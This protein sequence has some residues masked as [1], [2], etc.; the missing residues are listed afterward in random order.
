M[1]NRGPMA[2]GRGPGAGAPGRPGGG[3]MGMGG[4]PAGKARDLGKTLRQLLGRLRPEVPLIIGAALLG[5]GSVAFAVIGPKIIGNATNVIFN[6]IVG[7]MLPA[8]ITKAQ[9]VA[10]LHARGQDQLAQM[11]SGMNVTPGKG[12]D[13]GQLG[14]ILL[15]AVGV[16]VASSVFTWAQGYIMAG[17]A[18]R[19]VYGMRRDVESKLARLPLKYFDSHSHGD[20]LSLS[21]IHI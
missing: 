1:I 21:L 6:G 18:Q 16:Y 11:L 20:I 4:P 2:A 13:F 5:A 17:V 15:V 3:F 14:V 9:A 19:T 7:K 8:G 10:A 12:I